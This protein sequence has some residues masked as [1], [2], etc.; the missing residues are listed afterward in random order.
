MLITKRRYIA[1]LAVIGF[2]LMTGACE[3]TNPAIG[4]VGNP[5]QL[6]VVVVPCE[7]DVARN[8]AVEL[9][10]ITR[11]ETVWRI[12]S[13]AGSSAR[14]FQ[15]G[16]ESPGFTEEVA[17]QVSPLPEGRYQVR[18]DATE[19]YEWESFEIDDV[20]PEEVL[21][22][23]RGYVPMDDVQKLDSCQ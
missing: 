16:G 13:I 17:L 4:V 18:V 2:G 5:D 3:N 10:S 8:H 14:V 15:V 21:L 12:E 20:R 7:E 6:V 23:R 1:S 19:V 22:P 9:R 11:Q